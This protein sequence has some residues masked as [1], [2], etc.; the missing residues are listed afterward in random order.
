[1]NQ[2]DVEEEEAPLTDRCLPPAFD[3]EV[4][5]VETPNALRAAPQKK[6]S[7]DSWP[8]VKA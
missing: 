7:G 2:H 3:D 6:R 4:T 8:A 1:M 5:A